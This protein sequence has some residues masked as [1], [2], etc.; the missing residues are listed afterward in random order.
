MVWIGDGM[1][2]MWW[3]C[4]K[5]EKL[6]CWIIIDIGGVIGIEWSSEWM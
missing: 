2:M 1:M 6:V 5:M 3:I 4:G